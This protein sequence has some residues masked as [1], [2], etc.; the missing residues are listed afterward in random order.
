MKRPDTGFSLLELSLALIVVGLLTALALPLISSQRELAARQEALRLLDQVRDSLIGFAMTHG[1]LPCP[2]APE[3]LGRED[4]S[5]EH[6]VIPWATLALVASDPWGHQL[7]YHAHARFTQP[8]APGQASAITLDTTGQAR[9]KA[10]TQSGSDLADG[11]AA[12]I[13]CHGARAAGAWR[14]GQRVGSPGGD[15]AENADADLIF[16][17][18]DPGPDFDDLLIWISPAILKTRLVAAGRLP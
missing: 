7:T 15:E 18:R 16:V 11:L 2:A 4:C 17:H 1:R 8:P 13:V 9:I 3:G 10:S 12:V 6:G 14:N 5:R